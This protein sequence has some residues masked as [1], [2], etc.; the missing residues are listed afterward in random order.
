MNSKYQNRLDKKKV[1]AG[2]AGDIRNEPCGKVNRHNGYRERRLVAVHGEITMGMGR[3]FAQIFIHAD[4]SLNLDIYT[5][6]FV[7][8]VP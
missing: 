3:S 7:G 4:T 8:C 6:G 5:D 1:V 2:L